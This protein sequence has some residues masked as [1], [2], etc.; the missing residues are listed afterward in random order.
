MTTRKYLL[1]LTLIT[2]IAW[3]LWVMV[4][5]FIDPSTGSSLALLLFYL[6]LFFSLASSFTILGYLI[7]LLTA[8]GETT[9][10]RLSVSGRQGILF[11]VLVIASLILKANGHLNWITV[12]ISILI[13]SL[14]E[15]LFLSLSSKQEEPKYVE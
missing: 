8:G 5:K 9:G 13:L 1:Y 4:I 7:R 2:V 10:V 6:T 14:I 12:I 11:S 3:V 15:F